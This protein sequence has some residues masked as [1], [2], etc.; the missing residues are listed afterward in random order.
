MSHSATTSDTHWRLI[1]DLARPSRY[2]L[3]CV[4]SAMRDLADALERLAPYQCPVLILGEAGSGKEAV[5][6]ALHAQS[7]RH[8][9]PLIKFDCASLADTTAPMQLFGSA[10]HSFGGASTTIPGCFQFADGGSLLLDAV[11]QLPL[12]LQSKLLRAVEN[13]EV[14]PVGSVTTVHLDVRLFATT[15]RDLAAMVRAG[16]FRPD[17]YYRLLGASLR[18]PPLRDRT[19]DLE[20][21]IAD[22]VASYNRSLGKDVSA[23]SADALTLMHAHRWLGNLREMISVIERAMLFCDG[24][25]IGVGDLPIA[26][27]EEV[28]S[29]TPW[30]FPSG[31]IPAGAWSGADQDQASGPTIN[32]GLLDDAL[33]DAVER[34]LAAAHGDCGR[35]AEM[36]G[37]SR[38]A[39]YYKM[40]RFGL[41]SPALTTTTTNGQRSLRQDLR[42][43][44]EPDSHPD[45]PPPQRLHGPR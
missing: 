19:D 38:A 28:A 41:T 24:D 29:A 14:Q 26:I 20:P 5:A 12:G 21:L 1:T 35:A 34:S 3:I 36:L 31:A 40:V 15:N 8:D 23:I 4:S 10:Q 25:R 9:A 2:G 30:E 37:V 7:S 6:K 27:A 42:F 13:L 16:H 43:P 11:D 39:L 18:V 45:P 44:P 17:L 32:T 33:K 22:L